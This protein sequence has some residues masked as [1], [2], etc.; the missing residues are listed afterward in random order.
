MYNKNSLCLLLCCTEMASDLLSYR[1]PLCLITLSLK[2]TLNGKGSCD[3]KKENRS[4]TA[5]NL[6]TPQKLLLNFENSSASTSEGCTNMKHGRTENLSSHLVNSPTINKGWWWNPPCSGQI[7]HCATLISGCSSWPWINFHIPSRNILWLQITWKVIQFVEEYVSVARQMQT[8]EGNY[9]ILTL[10]NLSRE[11]PVTWMY[12]AK[13]LFVLRSGWATASSDIT[14]LV[15][16]YNW[17]LTKST[18]GKCG[19]L[20][21]G[22]SKGLAEVELKLSKR[23]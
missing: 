8:E 6:Q 17:K 11:A 19:G 14:V 5:N 20:A 22:I 12:C 13:L 16:F 15:C 4:R 3:N 9:W 7:D 2:F 21:G 18:S 1:K 23:V 10:C